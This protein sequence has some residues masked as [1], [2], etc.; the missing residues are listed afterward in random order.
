MRYVIFIV[1]S[2]FVLPAVFFS[3]KKKDVNEPNGIVYD[4]VSVSKIHHLDNDTTKPS[5]SV[6]VSYIYP[7]AYA[8]SAIL[9]KLRKEVSYA[10]F[11]DDSYESL[12]PEGALDKFVANYITN[13]EEDAK[14]RFSGWAD[15]YDDDE[16]FSFNKVL[17]THI[18]YDKAGLLSYQVVS[19]DSK[20]ES[21]TISNFRNVVVD[22]ENGNTLTELD[23]FIP[24][25]KSVLNHLITTKILEQ[26][27]ARN[28]E[29]LE[30]LGY[31]LSDFSSNNNF[32]VDSKGLTYIFN[33]G[34]YSAVILGEIRVPFTYEEVFDI[35]KPKSPVSHLSGK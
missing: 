16:Y 21:D 35:L 30:D 27:K 24:E 20:G 9:S 22:I 1:F 32:Y 11:E 7:A 3:C 5:C 14:L 2:L 19:R 23:I 8:D 13:Y 25:Y 34:E 26:K 12:S 29:E 17:D 31:F 18:L 4:S 33:P 28:A 15:H 6:Q 10:V